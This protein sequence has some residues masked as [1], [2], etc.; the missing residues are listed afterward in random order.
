MKLV[1]YDMKKL[2][3]TKTKILTILEEFEKSGLD[4]ARVEDHG[5]KNAKS[6]A[7]SLRM[8]VKRFHMN[9]IEVITRKD[10]VYMIHKR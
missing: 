5:C 9:N 1:P 10:Q 4:C 7:A 2:G 6:C 8:A 3:Y